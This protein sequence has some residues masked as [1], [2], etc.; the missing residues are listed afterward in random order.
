[1]WVEDAAFDNPLP[2]LHKLHGWGSRPLSV[3]GEADKKKK[4]QANRYKVLLGT[5]TYPLP[6]LPVN[7]FYYCIVHTPYI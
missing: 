2:L 4:T 7:P 5:H 6:R 3:K 1:M